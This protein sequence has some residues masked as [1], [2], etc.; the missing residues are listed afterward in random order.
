MRGDGGDR[1]SW[2]RYALRNG[3][4]SLL[5]ILFMAGFLGLLG[6]LLWGMSGLVL[7][8]LMALSVV[9]FNPALSPRW[10]MKLYGARPLVHGELPALEQV[11]KWLCERAG[12][13]SVPTLYLIPSRVMNGFSVGTPK[14]SA[15]ALSDAMIRRLTLRELVGVMAHEVSHIRHNDLWVMGLADLFSRLTSLLAFVGQALLVLNLP[16]MLLGLVTINWWLILLLVIAPVVSAL[17]QLALSRTREY[18]ADLNAARLTGDPQG[19]AQAL[20]LIERTQGGWLEHVFMPGRRVPEPSLLRTHPE[21]DERVERLLAL[22]QEF[23]P[24][25]TL[26]LDQLLHRVGHSEVSRRPRRGIWGTWW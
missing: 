8:V 19:L 26:P 2:R 21:T 18:A 20:D 23:D 6:W 16:L 5:L 4:Q 15:I 7:L 14:H 13:D 10:V 17:A 1:P 12:L 11:L 22:Q 9:V 25:D 3:L 24:Q